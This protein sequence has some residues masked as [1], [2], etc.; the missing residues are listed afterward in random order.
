MP[1]VSIIIPVH[2]GAATLG[3]CLDALLPQ[4][5]GRG[6]EVVVVDDGSDDTSGNVAAARKFCR[7]VRQANV[8]AAAARNRGLRES[9]AST[10]LFL[11]SD[12]VPRSDWVDAMLA[13]L[14]N[15][16]VDGLVGRFVSSQTGWVSRLIQ[17]DLD[18]RYAR[19]SRFSRIDFVNTATCAFHRRT[20][21]PDPFDEEFTKLEDL[22]LSFRLAARGA[23][24]R[25]HP[26]AVVEHRHPESL[27]AHARR[28]F[29]YGR[30]APRLYR[31]HAGKLA[32]DSSTPPSRRWQVLLLA[33][34]VPGFVVAWWLGLSLLAAS[35]AFSLP[36]VSRAFR[37]SPLLGLAAPVYSL[38][39]TAGFALGTALGLLEQVFARISKD[40]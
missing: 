26:E 14:Q 36:L 20:L 23:A 11:D 27:F 22:D 30:F 7:V 34:A 38:A 32:S 35:V 6:V 2:N 37:K 9:S 13:G 12:C 40:R 17:L 16:G 1:E 28:R 3:D 19:M 24:I 33:A 8:G 21:G 18:L 29:L 39:G 10:V 4:L 15:P 5:A 31:R 25:F